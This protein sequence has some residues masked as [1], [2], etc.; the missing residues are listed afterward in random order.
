MTIASLAVSFPAT[1]VTLTFDDGV[2]STPF[3]NPGIFIPEGYGGFNWNTMAVVDG[4]SIPSSGY[5]NA[6][7][8][9]DNVAYNS[10]GTAAQIFRVDRGTFTF[11]SAYFTAAW[12]DGLQIAVQGY[13]NGL[14]KSE[15]TFQVDTDD[16]VQQ[17]FNFIGIDELRFYSFGGIQNPK[18]SLSGTQFAMD[19]FV[20][21]EPI[22]EPIPTP[23]LLPGAIVWGLQVVRKQRQK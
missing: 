21:N 1:A 15:M 13:L 16:P 8:S 19:D 23:M 6:I 2:L 12:N 22:P 4:G 18:L 9:G 7:V 5:N 11:N 17:T 20:Y 14:L 10:G 3:Q